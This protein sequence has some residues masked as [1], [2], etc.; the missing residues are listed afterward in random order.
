MDA[1]RTPYWR[2]FWA[3]RDARPAGLLFLLAVIWLWA[4]APNRYWQWRAERLVDAALAESLA[5]QGSV[6]AD[7]QRTNT[8]PHLNWDASAFA[9]SGAIERAAAGDFYRGYCAIQ[10]NLKADRASRLSGARLTLVYNEG[11][12]QCLWW[13]SLAAESV[14]NCRDGKQ[15]FL[16]LK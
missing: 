9:Q 8:C 10:L 2:P 16:A 3:R 11:R 1:T 5:L 15:Q 12:W 4:E 13:P 7:W 6:K 14:G